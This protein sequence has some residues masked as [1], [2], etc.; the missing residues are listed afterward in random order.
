MEQIRVVSLCQ[1]CQAVWMGTH[2]FKPCPSCGS[3]IKIAMND[4][5]LTETIANGMAMEEA[6][7]TGAGDQVII[8]L[9]EAGFD[10]DPEKTGLERF[11]V[12][13]PEADPMGSGILMSEDVGP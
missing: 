10:F 1:G 4:E 8:H 13:D 3:T 9:A 2:I 7:G 5:V 12:T 6:L 11:K